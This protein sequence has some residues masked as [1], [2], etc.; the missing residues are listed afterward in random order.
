MI[1]GQNR[2]KEI[3]E[4]ERKEERK[5][6]LSK[7]SDST[8]HLP[9]DDVARFTVRQSAVILIIVLT[10]SFFFFV[11]EIF[12]VE[13]VVQYVRHFCARTTTSSHHDTSKTRH[14]P[15]HQPAPVVRMSQ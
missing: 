9:D 11:F 13:H 4:R 12:L 14:Q 15:K 2:K 1:K 3:S 10:Y 6:A 8:M 5:G 7:S